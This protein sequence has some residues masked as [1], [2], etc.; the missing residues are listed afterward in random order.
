MCKLEGII[1][2]S[3][4]P[5]QFHM[6]R[7]VP[8]ST[9]LVI[10]HDLVHLHSIQYAIAVLMHFVVQ[11][12]LHYKRFRALVRSWIRGLSHQ[13]PTPVCPCDWESRKDAFC[14][15]VVGSWTFLQLQQLLTP[16]HLLVKST[17]VSHVFMSRAESSCLERWAFWLK[18]LHHRLVRAVC[19]S[20]VSIPP[21]GSHCS[22]SNEYRER[23]IFYVTEQGCF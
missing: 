4:R 20:V 18:G 22:L 14:A 13:R 23:F 10:F 11:W 2:F 21:M 5:S 16:G 8:R 17:C 6:T 9:L 15:L 12:H 7:T 3:A 1:D 19:S